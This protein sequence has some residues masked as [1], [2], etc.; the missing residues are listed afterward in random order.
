MMKKL[1]LL[2]I[3][4]FNTSTCP[5]VDD[6]DSSQNKS[7]LVES[8]QGIISANKQDDS[9][10][11]G[12]YRV[13]NERSAANYLK[14]IKSYTVEGA[15]EFSNKTTSKNVIPLQ[16]VI[17]ISGDSGEYVFVQ[18]NAYTMREGK[19]SFSF[20]PTPGS[21]W[22]LMLASPK[23][24]VT[25]HGVPEPEDCYKLADI[26]NGVY[27]IDNINYFGDNTN[28]RKLHTSFK[29][30]YATLGLDEL[31]QIVPSIDKKLKRLKE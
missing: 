4:A 16:R 21:V 30:Q 7:E 15:K 11:I 23:N 9:I 29:E 18:G 12:V 28:L 24:K 26:D 6:T 13:L 25:D 19:P 1:F 5:A 27:Y 20:M 17:D 3:L 22:L 10:L 2:I 31:R 14:S 8:L